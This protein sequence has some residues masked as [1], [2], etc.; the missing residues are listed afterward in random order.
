MS[1]HEPTL[2]EFIDDPEAKLE[3]LGEVDSTREA[4]DADTDPDEE[5]QHDEV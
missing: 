1:G 5:Y 4:Q 3:A 2:D